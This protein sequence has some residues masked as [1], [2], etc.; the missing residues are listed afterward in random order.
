MILASPRCAKRPLIPDRP[1]FTAASAAVDLF[2][3]FS[4]GGGTS[5]TIKL[6]LGRSDCSG[7][8]CES[9]LIALF[10]FHFFSCRI[11]ALSVIQ[12]FGVCSRVDTRVYVPVKSLSCS[13]TIK[14]SGALRDR[15]V[16]LRTAT[17]TAIERITRIFGKVAA[18][19]RLIPVLAIVLCPL[20]AYVNPAMS[21]KN[22]AA[23]RPAIIDTGSRRVI[24]SSHVSSRLFV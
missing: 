9:I 3:E 24:V 8:T 22:G 14:A 16:F 11:R 20:E 4:A 18:A 17:T 21:L 12:T 1:P 19:H 5:R 23:R 2:H 6:A 15:R 10:H 13:A 7:R